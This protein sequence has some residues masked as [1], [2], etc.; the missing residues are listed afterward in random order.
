[1]TWRHEPMVRVC[2]G[3]VGCHWVPRP[4]LGYAKERSQSR[5]Q[6]HSL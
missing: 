2:N 3:I 1:V 5:E 4:W 6:S